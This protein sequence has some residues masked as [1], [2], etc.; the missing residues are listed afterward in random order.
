MRG[1]QLQELG[2]KEASGYSHD[3]DGVGFPGKKSRRRH[4]SD[5]EKKDTHSEVVYEN[6]GTLFNLPVKEVS[7]ISLE[8]QPSKNLPQRLFSAIK[9]K[10][11]R[12][13]VKSLTKGGK[14]WSNASI[15][16]ES[17]EEDKNIRPQ[18]VSYEDIRPQQVSYE[19]IR[20]QEYGNKVSP[21]R[22]PR[23]R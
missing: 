15:P 10:K 1:K 7:P 22:S 4:F 23:K 17:A 18:Q 8:K 2:N 3:H 21:R 12:K 9:K 5:N 20:P 13:I 14:S 19:D 6:V 16:Q 11:T